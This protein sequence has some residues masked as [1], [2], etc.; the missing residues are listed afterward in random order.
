[1]LKDFT[2]QAGR[3]QQ[4]RLHDW[5]EDARRDALLREARAIRRIRTAIGFGLI[6]LGERIAD[7]PARHRQTM[8]RAA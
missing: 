5:Q 8:E 2:S 4:A 1:M 6:A 7:P 3:L